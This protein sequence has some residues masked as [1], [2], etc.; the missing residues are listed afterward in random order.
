MDRK[1]LEHCITRL[2]D[3]VDGMRSKYKNGL[4]YT[5]HAGYDLGYWEGKLGVYREIL[6]EMDAQVTEN[7]SKLK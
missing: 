3:R 6:D 5:F 4:G 7:K 1:R 2:Q